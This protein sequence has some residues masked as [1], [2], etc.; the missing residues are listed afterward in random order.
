LL[1]TT[2][3][4]RFIADAMLGRLA[5]WLRIIGFDVLY[6]PDIEDRQMIRIALQEGRTILT[7][8]SGL[9]KNKGARN[10][11]FIASDDVQSQLRELRGKLCFEEARP[12]GRCAV[13]NGILSVVDRRDEVREAVPDF[14]YHNVDTF[15]CC[16]GCGKVYW[17]GSHREKFRNKIGELLKVEVED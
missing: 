17:P 8:D 13:C 10:A 1:R 15:L 14:I 3:S 12:L 7:R 6:Y 9:L 4:M 16:R 11:I 5:K 2:G